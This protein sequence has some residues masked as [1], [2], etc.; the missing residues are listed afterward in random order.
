LLRSRKEPHHFGG[1]GAA[2]DAAP[3]PNLMFTIGDYQKCHILQQFVT[4]Y[5]HF[6]INLNHKKSEVKI[7]STMMLTF[8]CFIKVGS[9]YRR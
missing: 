6:Y 2:G 1:A 7:K 9:V 3:A 4:F 5:T 8:V